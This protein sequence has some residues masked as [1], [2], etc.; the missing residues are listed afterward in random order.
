MNIG[1]S[2]I[3]LRFAENQNLKGKRR[4]IKS[5]CARIRN[6][7]N[8]SISE[9]DHQDSWQ[10]ATLGIS[11]VSNSASHAEEI[12]SNILSFIELSRNDAEIVSHDKEIISGF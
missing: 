1:V 11:C 3:T 2:K 10:L 7:F 6:K 12:L 8:V 5:L 4:I 9:G